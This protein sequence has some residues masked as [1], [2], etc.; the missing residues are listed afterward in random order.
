MYDAKVM[1]ERKTRETWFFRVCCFVV[2]PLCTP[3][4]D[5]ASTFLLLRRDTFA[6]PADYE[7]FLSFLFILYQC[8]IH[9]LPC[10]SNPGLETF[11]F[12]TLSHESLQRKK[13]KKKR[14][15][16]PLQWKS[17]SFVHDETLVVIESL[18]TDESYHS[19]IPLSVT[20]TIRFY[21]KLSRNIFLS[22]IRFE[23][24]CSR[25]EIESSRCYFSLA[26]RPIE[27]EMY[28]SR[29]MTRNRNAPFHPWWKTLPNGMVVFHLWN[30]WWNHQRN[31]FV[32]WPPINCNDNDRCFARTWN[33][34]KWGEG[35]ERERK[36][37]S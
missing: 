12:E 14:K 3:C 35:R 29:S 25:A 34:K 4:D 28:E 17:F 10:T 33:E 16:S 32:S 21:L 36:R 23:H 22:S 37:K 6:I 19:G 11:S 13:E 8:W 27:A 9:H 15:N 31:V 20:H 7:P 2:D 24:G 30:K 1:A 26:V 18:L 5:R